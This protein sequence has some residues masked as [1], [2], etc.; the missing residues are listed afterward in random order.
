MHELD[1]NYGSKICRSIT[2][3]RKSRKCIYA[4]T[5]SSICATSFSEIPNST[6]SP[7]RPKSFCPA[8]IIGVGMAARGEIWSPIQRTTISDVFGG[9]LG[10]SGRFQLAP[11]SARS[12][13]LLVNWVRRRET[14]SRQDGVKGSWRLENELNLAQSGTSPRWKKRP[15]RFGYFLGKIQTRL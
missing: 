7:E 13:G 15:K 9:D 1:T 14:E 11:L 8:C 10:D 5:D 3:H 12:V 2:D 4:N 6:P